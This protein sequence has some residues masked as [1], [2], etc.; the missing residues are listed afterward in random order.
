M[1]LEVVELMDWAE[2]QPLV[3]ELVNGRLTRLSEEHQGPARLLAMQRIAEG[4]FGCADRARTWMA[5]P[6]PMLGGLSPSILAREGDEGSQLALKALVRWHR[7]TLSQ[8]NA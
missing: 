5:A 2:R 7:S 8:A 1:V 4:V 6:S 3:F